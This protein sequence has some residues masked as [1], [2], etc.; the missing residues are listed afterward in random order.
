MKANYRFALGL[1]ACLLCYPATAQ[2][3]VY[4]DMAPS[5]WSSAYPIAVTSVGSPSDEVGDEIDLAPSTPRTLTGLTIQY[6]A[7]N[8]D[9]SNDIRVRLYQNDGPL[10]ANAGAPTP[11]TVLYDSGNLPLGTLNGRG[12]LALN[13]LSVPV[14]DTLI[15][16]VQ[17]TGLTA[18]K[19]AGLAISGDAN[20]GSSFDDFWEKVNG[21]WDIYTLPSQYTSNFGAQF[22]ASAIPEPNATVSVM[23]GMAFLSVMGLRFV[24]AAGHILSADA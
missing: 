7:Q 24:R 23:L 6:L 11:Q 12:T 21:A 1:A 9:S 5:D 3:V 14:P 4:D 10:S 16:T 17:F 8:L 18:N 13:N 15:W 22:T 20:P 2:V 19:V